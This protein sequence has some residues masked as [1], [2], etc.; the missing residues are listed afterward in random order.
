VKLGP[1]EWLAL[2]GG[3]MIALLVLSLGVEH[4]RLVSA[5]ADGA[6]CEG[7]VA[8]FDSAQHGNLTTIADLQRRLAALTEARKVEQQASAR[9]V[10]AAMASAT[11]ADKRRD[12]VEARLEQ[13]YAQDSNARDWG[14]AGVDAG[15]AASLPKR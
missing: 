6:A 12:A 10:A 13:L 5:R 1:L 11:E 2:I 15:V 3:V 14:N 8:N 9:A 4:S 7:T